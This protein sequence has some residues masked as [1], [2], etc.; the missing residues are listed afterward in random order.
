MAS[1][2]F[3]V[4]CGNHPRKKNKEHIL[5]QWLIALTGSPSRVVNVAL[6][7]RNGKTISFSWSSFVAP[8][9]EKC[10]SAY[11]ELECSAKVLVQKLIAR[12]E[13]TASEYIVLLDWL[14]KTRIGLWLAY[15]QLL[16][17]PANIAPHLHISDRIASK[18]RMLAV[19]LIQTHDTG[20]NPVGIETPMFHHVPSC[21]MLKVHN[22]AILNM[23]CDYLFAGRCGFPAPRVREWLL[24]GTGMLSCGEFTTSR[25][26]THPILNTS[27]FKPSVHL[28]Q[29]IMQR[30]MDDKEHESYIGACNSNHEFFC[31]HTIPSSPNQGVLFRQE[32]LG[33]DVIS[34]LDTPIQY[35]PVSMSEAQP[36]YQLM[37]QTYDLQNYCQS[38]YEPR[39]S[40]KITLEDHRRYFKMI[41]HLNQQR[42]NQI[43]KCCQQGTDT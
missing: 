21:F 1:N 11:A 20:M 19:Y 31:N 7:Y 38:L 22:I 30:G 6:D 2:Q 27:I 28:Y 4:F 8:A 16:K 10:N 15:Y 5:P 36:L 41:V 26:V 32:P 33:V 29:P 25:Q 34:D 23:S 13:L 43:I 3:C 14:D 12:E 42:R 17:N 40:N 18:D 35:A 39:S 9:C 24:D 37:A